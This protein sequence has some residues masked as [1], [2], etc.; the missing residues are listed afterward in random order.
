MYSRVLLKTTVLIELS[1]FSA[2]G[3]SESDCFCFFLCIKIAYWRK[4]HRDALCLN[5]NKY[6]F[7]Y[8]NALW[9]C[10]RTFN[11]D[12]NMAPNISLRTTFS[13][14]LRV[15]LSLRKPLHYSIMERYCRHNNK[16]WQRMYVFRSVY[17]LR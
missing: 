2:I 7:Q 11:R 8:S 10:S 1:L 6:I 14:G 15:N 5:Y 3:F 9:K 17:S 12:S 16:I 13:L 4:I